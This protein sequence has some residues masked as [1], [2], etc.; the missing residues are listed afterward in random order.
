MFLNYTVLNEEDPALELVTLKNYVNSD[1]ERMKRY[2]LKHEKGKSNNKC[3]NFIKLVYIRIY[4]YVCIFNDNILVE[5]KLIHKKDVKWNHT[6]GA[7]TAKIPKY[8]VD[9]A[10]I[11]DKDPDPCFEGVR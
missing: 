8:I 11:I 7:I 1:I 3:V 10:K 9:I 4:I 2:Y 5:L 6:K